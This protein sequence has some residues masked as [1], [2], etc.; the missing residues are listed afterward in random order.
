VVLDIPSWLFPD[1]YV[2]NKTKLLEEYRRIYSS[3]VVRQ[4]PNRTH[5]PLSREILINWTTL[6]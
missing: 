6:K 5:K 1:L 4:D 2:K 3:S